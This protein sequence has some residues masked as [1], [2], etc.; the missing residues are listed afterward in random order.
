MV[1]LIRRKFD[2]MIVTRRNE[3]HNIIHSLKT[4]QDMQLWQMLGRKTNN[5][6]RVIDGERDAGMGAKKG[7]RYKMGA[8]LSVQDELQ[9]FFADTKVSDEKISKVPVKGTIMSFFAKKQQKTPQFTSKA[10]RNTLKERTK[11]ISESYQKPSIFGNHSKATLEMIEWDCEACTLHNKQRRCNSDTPACEICGTK[12]QEVIEIDDQ[13]LP[14]R[15]VTP[16]S[17]RKGDS[18]DQREI[19]QLPKSSSVKMKT[20]QSTRPLKPEIVTIDDNEESRVNVVPRNLDSSLAN[21]IILCDGPDEATSQ[22]KRK[23][24]HGQSR[25]KNIDLFPLSNKGRPSTKPV[26]TLSFSVSRNSGR[27]TIHFSDSGESSLT[28][29]KIE[30]IVTEETA[31]RLTEAIISRNIKAL[32]SIKVEYD[33]SA[34]RKGKGMQLL[35]SILCY[36]DC[37]NVPYS[38]YNEL[39]IDG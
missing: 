11:R 19:N 39:Y 1:S 38:L 27:I 12:Y 14:S 23:F 22:K 6:G 13:D 21:P 20:K 31:D 34:L 37:Y 26:T 18:M 30:Q 7:D 28:N 33:H 2:G 9:S 29:F 15:K 8:G 36:C 35:K 10:A 32:A 3:P 25:S 16:V 24:S 5:L 17:M 4:L